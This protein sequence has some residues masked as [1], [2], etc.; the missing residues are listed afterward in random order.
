MF[1]RRMF[2]EVT[3]E[4]AYNSFCRCAVSPSESAPTRG[5]GSILN[6]LIR[7]ITGAAEEATS[8][9]RGDKSLRLSALIKSRQRAGL[10]GEL[11]PYSSKSFVVI[12]DSQHQPD[13]LDDQC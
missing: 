7:L 9:L 3:V 8:H 6:R 2:S 12:I 10:E 13:E 11:Q 4:D 1:L 5:S